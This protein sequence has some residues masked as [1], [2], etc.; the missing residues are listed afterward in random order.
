MSPQGIGD[1]WIGNELRQV[2]RAGVPF[3]LHALRRVEKTPYFTSEWFRGLHERTR[4]IQ[5]AP[6]AGLIVSLLAAPFLFRGRFFAAL[7]NV[8]FGRRE[9]IRARVACAWNFVLACHWARGLRRE[10]VSHIHSQWIHSAGTVAWYGARLLGVPFSFTGHAADLF[11]NRCA[12]RDKIRDAAFIGCISEFHR[13]LYRGLGAREEQMFL[14]YCGIDVA[15]FTPRLRERPAG[16]PLCVL[17]SGRLV[18]KKGFEF[19]IDAMALLRDRGSDVR[20]VIGGSGPLEAS[21]RARVEER[22]LGDRVTLTGKAIAQEELPA[23]MAQGDVYCLPCV[24]ASDDDVDGLPQML[25]EAMACGLPAVSTRLV[26]IPDLVVHEETGLL[27]EPRRADQLADALQRVLDDEPLA[28]RLAGAGR[29]M[30]ETRFDILTCLEPLIER[31]RRR[32]GT[33]AAS[34]RPASADGAPAR[35]EEGAVA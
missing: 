10:T 5:P 14:V 32:L 30:V 28:R 35:A 29:R 7:G 34:A 31:Y 19:L 3:A 2:D 17:S 8:L 21:L 4:A 25:V 6:V 33:S 1:A 15:H 16:G 12:L 27:V 20:C 11:R 18:E 22:G 26:G 24:W 13:E 9:S 23:F